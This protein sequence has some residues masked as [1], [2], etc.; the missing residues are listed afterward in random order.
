MLLGYQFDKQ[1]VL[2]IMDA[3]TYDV[4]SGGYNG[5]VEGYDITVAGMTV[6]IGLGRAIIKGRMI[7]NTEHI[8]ITVPANTTTSIC[9]SVDLS[10]SNISS[11]DV[12]TPDYAVINNQLSVDIV[13]D[14]VTDDINNGVDTRYDLIIATVISTT[15][16]VSATAENRTPPPIAAVAAIA[17]IAE[18]VIPHMQQTAGSAEGVH[19]FRLYESE[20][21]YYNEDTGEW[22]VVTGGGIPPETYSTFGVAIDLLDSNPRTCVTYTDDAVGMTGGSADWD[23]QAIF[24]DIRPCTLKNGSVNYYLDPKNFA[25][26]ADGAI[27][28]I[29]SGDDGDVMIEIPKIGFAISTIENTLTVKITNK[30][31]DPNFHYY[32]HTRNAE[33]DR[34]KL[35]I[36]AYDGYNLSSKLRSLSGSSPAS[37]QAIGSFRTLAQANGSGYDLVSFYPLT[38]LQCLYLIRYKSLDSQTALGKGSMDRSTSGQLGAGGANAK[39][40]NFGETTGTLAMKFIGIENFWGNVN[41]FIDGLYIDASKNI[42]TAFGSFNNTGSGYTNQGVISNETNSFVNKVIGTTELGF[43]PSAAGGSQST[44]FSDWGGISKNS[45]AYFGSYWYATYSAG[46]FAFSVYRDASYSNTIVGARLMYL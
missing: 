22:T 30:P 7:E 29:T 44:Y 32:A 21:Q 27:A 8:D 45:I 10:Q 36:G 18:S 40:M 33:G 26:S 3:K 13:D 43:I 31:D 11:G 16:S 5:V 4:L 37:N 23:T 24:K 28:D 39:G 2:P 6:T 19:G 38:L 14:P 12:G 34:E 35:Y 1:N 20:L 15:S 46:A 25:R 9:L 42:L 17:E 41:W